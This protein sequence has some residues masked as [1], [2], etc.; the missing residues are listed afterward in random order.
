MYNI[1]E[2]LKPLTSEFEATIP[3]TMQ[4]PA[5]PYS[6]SSEPGCWSIDDIPSSPEEDTLAG[7]ASASEQPS[8]SQTEID[9]VDSSLAYYWRTKYPDLKGGSSMTRELS[10]V[11]A[12][13][14]NRELSEAVASF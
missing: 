3:L 10:E 7:G 13:N 11:E 8:N 12:A 4:S 2:T 14:L 5:T 9:V 6:T 1:Q